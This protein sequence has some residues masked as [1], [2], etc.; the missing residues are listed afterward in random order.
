M[1]LEEH[2]QNIGMNSSIYSFNS[3]SLRTYYMLSTILNTW[4]IAVNQTYK[5]PVFMEFTLMWEERDDKQ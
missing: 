5:S 2:A 3:Y 1:V 4:K